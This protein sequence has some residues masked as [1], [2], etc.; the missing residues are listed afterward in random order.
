MSEVSSASSASLATWIARS[1]A[2]SDRAQE[3]TAVQR[4]SEARAKQPSD[5]RHGVHAMT[6]ELDFSLPED[7]YAWSAADQWAEPPITDDD[8]ATF[9]QTLREFPDVPYELALVLDVLEG[10]DS[11]EM[12]A[13][14]VV[15]ERLRRHH[16]RHN[17]SSAP[18]DR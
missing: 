7:G 14:A 15:A 12:S 9:P 13:A 1:T 18:G 10:P 8:V 4:W 2:R 16:A 11:R 5:L 6:D 17:A 3:R